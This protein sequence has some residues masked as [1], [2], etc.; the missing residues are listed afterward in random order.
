MEKNALPIHLKV[1]LI[2]PLMTLNGTK[3]KK[4]RTI[5]KNSLQ[6]Y[7]NINNLYT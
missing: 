2:N 4:K 1:D 6:I 5:Q 3:K 7:I